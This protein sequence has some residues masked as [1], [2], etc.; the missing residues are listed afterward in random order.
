MIKGRFGFLMTVLM[1]VFVYLIAD[2]AN[3]VAIQVDQAIMK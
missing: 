3:A 2:R 1:C